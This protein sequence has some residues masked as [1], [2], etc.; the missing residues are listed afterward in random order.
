M[1]QMIQLV[2][3]TIQGRYLWGRGS[4]RKNPKMLKAIAQ[5]PG[6]YM[7]TDEE[8]LEPTHPDH[9][10]LLTDQTLEHLAEHLRLHRLSFYQQLEM[11]Q[12]ILGMTQTESGQT[13]ERPHRPFAQERLDHIQSLPFVQHA[14]NDWLTILRVMEI[15]RERK[16]TPPH[17]YMEMIYH[18][19]FENDLKHIHNAISKAREK[20]QPE[21]ANELTQLLQRNREYLE[22]FYR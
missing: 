6:K 22:Q 9:L 18:F 2:T 16:F 11:Y 8:R 12:Q 14:Y 4:Q 19:N 7:L 1:L 21:I 13:L 5:N 10:R 3:S 20:G 17:A 15:L